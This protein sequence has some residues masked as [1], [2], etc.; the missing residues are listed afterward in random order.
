MN[1]RRVLLAFGILLVCG[2]ARLQAQET[3]PKELEFFEQKIRPV[4]VQHCYACHSEKAAANGKLKA[5]LLLDSR[6][7]VAKGGDTGPAVIPKKS[8]ESLL[9]K[10]LRYDGVEMPPAGKLSEN[11]IADFVRW[12]DLGAPDPRS[13][14]AAQPK[15]REIDLVAGRQ[16]WSFQPLKEAA[17]PEVA[18]AAWAKTPIDR[19]ILAKQSEKG[20]TAS[21]PAG[22]EK[23]LR[24]V[25]FD[26]I[27]LPPTPEQVAA[28]VADASP[29]AFEKIVDGLLASDRYGERWARHWLD[30]VRFAESGG[31]EFDGFRPGAYHYRDW[32]I[33]ALNSDLPYDE[34]VRMQI[35]GDKLQPGFQGAA[36]TGFL[37]AGPF[38]GQITAKTE[39]RIR[40]D[41]LDDM[42]MTIGG[43]ML[44]V[45]LGCVRCHD[46][47]YDPIPQ[48]DY[49]GI[50]AAL[51]RTGHGPATLDPDPAATQRALD[52]HA[53]ELEQRRAALRKFAAE[54]FAAR[55][56][57]WQKDDLPKLTAEPRWQVLTPQTVST[58]DTWLSTT[59]DGLVVFSG[60]R[61]K[62]GDTYVVSTHTYQ[63][64]LVSLRLDA[65][66][67]KSMP[68]KGPGFGGDGSFTLGEFKAVARP[69]DPKSAEPPVTLKLKPV[70]AAFEEPG[71]PLKNVVDGNPATFW[72]ANADGGKD[73]AAL[74][75]IEGGLPGFASGTQLTFEL[76]FISDGLGRFRL[77]ASSEPGAPTWAG[78][79]APQ[80]L[81]EI[82]AILAA[83]NN[84]LPEALR[85]AAARWF[86]RFDEAAG[87]LCKSV[88]D[89]ARAKPRPPLT[90]VYTAV[91][92]GRDVFLLRRGEVDGK[93]GQ[94]QP[95]FLQVLASSPNGAEKWLPKPAAGQPALDPRVGLAS[96]MTDVEQGAGA[97]LARVIVNRL[98]QH[99]FGR[100]LVNTPNDFGAQGEKPTHPE[101]LDWL[102]RELVKNGW[103][104]KPIHKLIVQSA[105]YQEGNDVTPANVKADPLNQYLWHYRPRRLEAEVIRDSI[106]AVGATLDTTMYGPS[107]LDNTPRRSVYLRVKRSELIP[108]MTMFDA[109]EPTQSIGERISTTVPTQALAM[110]NSPF[111][112][113]QAERLAQRIRPAPEVA[114]PLAI[115]N[116]YQIVFCRLPTPAER[117]RMLAFVEQ[118]RQTAGGDAPQ[119]TAAAL[120]EFCQLLLCLNEFVYVD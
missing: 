58:E 11:V 101:L 98:W 62:N 12:V 20:L 60:P 4:L 99:H 46:H 37:V 38:P 36:A 55:F 114:L 63:K 32:V 1:V 106:L 6:E 117:E 100:G 26:L 94:A 104:L 45:T 3:D 74:F 8:A 88:D 119:H 68:R 30:A 40:Y 27:G 57:R 17:P 21:A 35:A 93:I 5:K 83:N 72:R 66:T 23:L 18:N 51:G 53:A 118:Q 87:K 112:R 14:K 15:P 95:A 2:T 64:N 85:E 33:R 113:Q 75:E 92:G 50:A 107:I 82:K 111:V 7:G 28:F 102:A 110:M 97:L 16:F 34:F 73:N 43:S 31:Y 67:D 69:L 9:I 48:Q 86:G 77:A 90:E 116:A 54:D 22:K 19:F 49:Y 79:V 84:T 105:V 96:W 29:N 91:A 120:V 44:G 115:D 52:Q 89:H 103:K 61:R 65:F 25:Y 71:Q 41:Q 24:R 76:K 70:L 80:H 10:A 109:P 42:I 59:D 81:G 39:E 13:G 78:E 56:A 108:F 47:K